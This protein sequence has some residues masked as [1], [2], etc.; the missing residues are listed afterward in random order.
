MTHWSRIR[1]WVRAN[2]RRSRMESDMDAELL[3][4]VEAHAAEL[5]RGG[6]A[7]EEAMRRAKVEFGGAGESQRGV[8]RIARSTLP[9]NSNA[10][11]ALRISATEQKPSFRAGRNPDAGNRHRREYGDLHG[12]SCSLAQAVAL[13][14]FR[15]LGHYLVRTRQRT[16]RARLRIRTSATTPT[17]AAVRSD[18]RNLGP[19]FQC[20]GRGRTG[21][22]EVWGGD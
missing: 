19:Q 20:S 6:V 21:A 2:L 15:A 5:M 16:P 12:C 11:R 10:G 13:S 4:H 9:G 3:F 18:R 14:E 8:P 1:S 17:I 7:R 22:G